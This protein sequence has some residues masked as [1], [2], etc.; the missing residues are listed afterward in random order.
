M[1]SITYN[2]IKSRFFSKIEDYKFLTEYEDFSN[3]FIKEWLRSTLAKPKVRRI[4]DALSIDEEMDNFDFEIKYPVDDFS[5]AE[6]VIDILAYGIVVG[7]LEPKVQSTINIQQ[8]Y[9]GKEEKFYAQANHL[10]TIKELLSES[11]SKIGKLIRDRG[12][13]Y[14]SYL[15]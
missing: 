3:E 8:M 15:G 9:G 2:Q 4:F 6:Y 5:D 11:S 7:W 10:D 13:I 14:N 1:P 12:Y